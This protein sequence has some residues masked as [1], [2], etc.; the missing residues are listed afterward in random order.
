M[1][2][3]VWSRR[4]GPSLIRSTRSI[5][6]RRRTLLAALAEACSLYTVHGEDTRQARIKAAQA[7]VKAALEE[8]SLPGGGVALMRDQETGS[9]WQVL[10]GWAVS[11]P[12]LGSVLQCLPSHY[13][14]WFA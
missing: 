2:A 1:L 10:T 12:L 11:V 7:A 8:G 13:S 14:F 9:L 5:T 3:P 4:A 6:S